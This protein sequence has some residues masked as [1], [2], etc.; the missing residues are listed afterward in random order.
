MQ[1]HYLTGF[2]KRIIRTING[3][4]ADGGQ[5]YLQRACLFPSDSLQKKVVPQADYWLRRVQE[6]DGCEP[7]I[8]GQGFLRLVLELRVILLQD[9]VMLRS[10][11]GLQSSSIF[12][13]PLF[14]DP[15]FLEFERRLLDISR[16]EPDPQQQR[17]QSVIPI[18]DNRLTAIDTKVDAN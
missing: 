7:T 4:P 12:N 15:E 14:S 11:P 17:P 10:V 1:K 16:R 9:V 6:G 18:V 3:F 5:Y 2:P 13:H 8:C